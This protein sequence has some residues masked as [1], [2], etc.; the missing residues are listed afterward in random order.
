MEFSRFEE[1]KDYVKHGLADDHYSWDN[2]HCKGHGRLQWYDE[3]NGDYD[4]YPSKILKSARFRDGLV[5]DKAT[6]SEF[7]N[8]FGFDYWTDEFVKRSRIVFDYLYPRESILSCQDN[9]HDYC[10]TFVKSRSGH[11]GGI[12]LSARNQGKFLHYC[13]QHV[14][15]KQS[16]SFMRDKLFKV[17]GLE[18][19]KLPKTWNKNHRRTETQLKWLHALQATLYCFYFNRM[20]LTYKFRGEADVDW[21]FEELL[22]RFKRAMS[23]LFNDNVFNTP[24]NSKILITLLML[25]QGIESGYKCIVEVM[26]S[27]ERATLFGPVID[28]YA[29][30][31]EKL[32]RQHYG[33]MRSLDLT[34]AENSP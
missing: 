7:S 2:N 6:Y 5:A 19:R 33:S 17:L 18:T 12:C 31:S 24:E 23:H 21:V 25:M 13:M 9:T 22:P 3:L 20:W 16:Q 1:V 34:I 15:G 32:Y 11:S 29:P 8:D 28:S 14:E 27:E 4:G 30:E 26:E 10:Q